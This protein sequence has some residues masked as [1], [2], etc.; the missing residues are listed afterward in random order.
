MA[1]RL[2][3]RFVV[4]L[5]QRVGE[6]AN[7]WRRADEVARYDGLPMGRLNEVLIAATSAGLIDRHASDRDLVTLTA[8]GQLAARSGPNSMTFRARA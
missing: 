4:A 3:S 5:Y 8:S 6:A 1:S 2:V 7:P